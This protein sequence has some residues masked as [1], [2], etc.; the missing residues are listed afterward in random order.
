M[1][2]KSNTELLI[3]ELVQLPDDMKEKVAIHLLGTVQGMK[4]AAALDNDKKSA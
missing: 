1:G 2:K 3:E 4:I